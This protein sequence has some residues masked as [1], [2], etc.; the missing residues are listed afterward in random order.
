MLTIIGEATGRLPPVAPRLRLPGRGGPPARAWP[1]ILRARPRSVRAVKLACPGTRGGTAGW[2]TN[3]VSAAASI[4]GVVTGVLPWLPWLPGSS[5]RQQTSS[6]PAP[7]P[8]R[9]CRGLRGCPSTSGAAGKPGH[10]SPG[11]C[12]VSAAYS[13]LPSPI[14]G[15]RRE[16]L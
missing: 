3:G 1:G 6:R 2:G 5:T 8:A 4:A 15:W 14:R 11:Q 7:T 9:T 12:A 16:S 13:S 10:S